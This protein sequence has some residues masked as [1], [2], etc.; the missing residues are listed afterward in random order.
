MDFTKTLQISQMIVNELSGSA[1]VHKMQGQLFKS[2]GFTKLGQKYI[3]HYAEEMEWVE[4]YTDRMLDLGCV[5][6]VKVCNESTLVKDAKSYIEAD[7]K[8]QRE[9]VE[10]LYKIM[11]ELA[12]DPTTYDLTKAYLLDEEEDLYWDEEQLDLIEKIGYQ[13]WLLKMM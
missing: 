9:G 2:Q 4:K 5:P 11:P 10:E 1:L 6:Q 12:S 7:L 8:L 13:N 3:D